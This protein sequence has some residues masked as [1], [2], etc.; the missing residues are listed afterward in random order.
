[1]RC[2]LIVESVA[3]PPDI[4]YRPMS[5]DDV[6]RVPT[7]HQGEVHGVLDRIATIGSCAWLAFDGD[8]HI[9]Q[10]QFRLHV[11]DTRS[12]K[13]VWDPLWW[14]DFGGRPLLSTHPPSPSVVVT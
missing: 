11:V 2:L 14:M 7:A 8:R 1:M 3:R 12:P 13:E 4:E 9:G 5:A 10:R 6:D